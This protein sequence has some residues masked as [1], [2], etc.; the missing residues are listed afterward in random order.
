[1]ASGKRERDACPLSTRMPRD[2]APRPRVH[3]PSRTDDVSRGSGS[4]GASVA[5]ASVTSPARSMPRMSSTVTMA[6]DGGAKRRPRWSPGTSARRSTP[7][8]SDRCE[9]GLDRALVLRSALPAR[10]LRRSL[11]LPGMPT[12]SQASAGS[13]GSKTYVGTIS[14]ATFPFSAAMRSSKVCP[15]RSTRRAA[16]SPGQRRTGPGARR[17]KVVRAPARRVDAGHR[18]DVL[19]CDP[20]PVRPRTTSGEPPSP[21]LVG[22][23]DFPVGIDLRDGAGRFVRTTRQSRRRRPAR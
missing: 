22:R 5:R 19:V 2:V 10:G 9:V 17:N 11:A 4:R 8:G 7:A 12:D 16:A 18:P 14:F 20:Q 3:W 1:M 13:T 15:F 23:H 6:P 21:G